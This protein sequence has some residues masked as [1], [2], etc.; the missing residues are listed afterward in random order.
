MKWFANGKNEGI[1]KRQSRSQ[2]SICECI[3]TF[4]FLWNIFF[5]FVFVL[6]GGTFCFIQLLAIDASSKFI[7]TSKKKKIQPKNSFA[8]WEREIAC[9]REFIS[10]CVLA[11][12]SSRY[13]SIHN[14]NSMEEFKCDD[15]WYF[16]GMHYSHPFSIKR[17]K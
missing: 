13:W 7:T 2:F 10:I 6:F 12:C 4:E 15:C 16:R 3:F 1:G 9:N 8:N 5:F 11:L 14:I 17:D